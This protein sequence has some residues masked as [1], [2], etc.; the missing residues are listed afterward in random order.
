M[1]IRI[2]EEFLVHLLRTVELY[3]SY[4]SPV[5]TKPASHLYDTLAPFTGML[6]QRRTV[7][8]FQ[9]PELL[10][11]FSADMIYF[12]M[13]VINPF[14]LR[15]SF[16][17]VPD[18]DKTSLR[19]FAA[20]A[21]LLDAAGSIAN[22]DFAPIALNGLMLKNPFC[23]QQELVQRISEHYRTAL[24]RGVRTKNDCHAN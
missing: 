11:Q 17:S 22:V 15:V 24:L 16:A 6:T 5:T 1:D 7:F 8:D 4:I 19:R 9:L 14:K 2:D 3:R 12:E 18:V 21:Q 20:V 13:L 23:S 10:D